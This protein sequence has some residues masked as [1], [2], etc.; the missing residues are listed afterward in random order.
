[1]KD[2]LC[3]L[4]DDGSDDIVP[5]PENTT[6]SGF[7]TDALAMGVHAMHSDDE[8]LRAI[9]ARKSSIHTLQ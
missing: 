5:N 9:S 3:T 2:L 1:M 8:L 7:W 4:D 6:T